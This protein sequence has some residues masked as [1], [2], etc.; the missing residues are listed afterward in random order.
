MASRE[1]DSIYY[2]TISMQIKYGLIKWSGLIRGVAFGGSVLIR[3]GAT[4]LQIN[5]IS[6]RVNKKI[7]YPSS[8]FKCSQTCIKRTK[9]KW[10]FKTSDLLKEVQFI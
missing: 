9:K 3:R 2:F 1:G 7:T 6:F 4:V 8:R 10:A 5:L